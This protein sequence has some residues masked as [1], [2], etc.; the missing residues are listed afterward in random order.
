MCMVHF[1]GSKFAK[2]IQGHNN[3][4]KGIYFI[5]TEMSYLI[6]STTISII[7]KFPNSKLLR[8]FYWHVI[9]KNETLDKMEKRI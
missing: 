5:W 6:T 8:I 9:K 2:K 1:L 7:F 4:L 3:K